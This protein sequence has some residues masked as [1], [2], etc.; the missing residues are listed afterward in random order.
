LLDWFQIYSNFTEIPWG[1]IW[2]VAFLLILAASYALWE[3]LSER[4][5]KMSAMIAVESLADELEFIDTM[6][7]SYPLTFYSNNHQLLERNL[8]IA[9][10]QLQLASKCYSEHQWS[11]CLERADHGMVQIRLIRQNLGLKHEL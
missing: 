7:Q 9:R 11:F 6:Q 1:G 8:S 4:R 2:G 3:Q 5:L 10:E